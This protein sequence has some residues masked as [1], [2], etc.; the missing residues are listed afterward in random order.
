MPS[1]PLNTAVR[2]APA[3][4]APDRPLG[5]SNLLL[6]TGGN[7]YAPDW[8]KYTSIESGSKTCVTFC[9]DATG[10]PAGAVK[11]GPEVRAGYFI[12]SLLVNEAMDDKLC[13][14][15]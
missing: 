6:A 15:C 14:I 11:T 13:F 5:G 9:R 2:R 1:Q 10:S 4:N 3:D 8:S 12:T 7:A